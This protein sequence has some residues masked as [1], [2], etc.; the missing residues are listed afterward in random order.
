VSRSC[1]ISEV[2]Q[3]S[4]DHVSVL[5]L[6]GTV[7]AG[8]TAIAYEIGELLRLTRVVTGVRV[9][10]GVI[11]LDALSHASAGSVED[12]FNSKFVVENLKAVWPNYVARGVDH[13]VLA[14]YVA[15]AHELDAY[16]EAI[17]SATLTVCR[18]TAPA[19]TIQDRLRRRESGLAR[20]FLMTLS[21]T[22][23][24]ESEG[25]A[26]EDF[27]VDNGPDRSVTDV[28]REV[29]ERLGWPVP[30]P[31]TDARDDCAGAVHDDGGQ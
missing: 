8:K 24:A 4:P 12:R 1:I 10:I 29:A 25:L 6:T 27:A 22:L 13:L 23:A 30:P 16:R 28:A 21:Q 18:I 9:A 3:A 15:A 17:P 26:F 19:T 2:N 31:V 11:D 5:L 7:G 14:R 20:D